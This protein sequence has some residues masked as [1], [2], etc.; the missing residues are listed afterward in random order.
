MRITADSIVDA[1][2]MTFGAKIFLPDGDIIHGKISYTREGPKLSNKD[3]IPIDA[4]NQA[5][6]FSI[7]GIAGESLLVGKQE[8]ISFDSTVYFR[9]LTRE[10]PATQDNYPPSSEGWIRYLS[11][12]GKPARIDLQKIIDSDRYLLSCVDLETGEM[13][14][15]HSIRSFETNILSMVTDWEHYNREI[16]DY[17]EEEVSLDSLL[18]APA[19]SWADL[20]L[21]VQGINIPNLQRYG[22][23]GE[24]LSQIVP[25][26]FP[27]DIRKELMTFLAWTIRATIPREDPLDFLTTIHRRFKTGPL[28]QGLVFGHVQC[29]IQQ[30]PIPQYVRIFTMA[31]RGELSKGEK[32]LT[33]NAEQEAWSKAWFRVE[34]LFPKRIDRIID[35]ANHL[36]LSQEIHADLPVSKQEA[37]N[38][39][40]AW[41]DRFALIRSNFQMRGYIQ[42]RKIGLQKTVYI[43]GAH[44]WPHTHLQYAARLGHPNQKPPY[45]QVMVMPKTAADRISRI[46]QNVV[47]IDWTA[48][49]V[50]YNLYDP[51]NDTWKYNASRFIKSFRGVRTRRLMNKEFEI[52][53][54]SDIFHLDELDPKLLD[55]MSWGFYPQSFEIGVYQDSLNPLNNQEI[56]EKMKLYLKEKLVRLHYYPQTFGR[57][58]ICLE[59]RGSIKK[60][61]SISRAAL[62]HLPSAVVMISTSEEVCIILARIPEKDIYSIL[63]ELPSIAN[64]NDVS[65]KAY[66]VYAYAGFV[67]NLYQ[68]LRRPDGTWDDDVSGLLS[69]ITN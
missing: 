33:E 21:L 27:E 59:I 69:Q 49:R 47:S 53:S 64:E 9:K 68:R 67:H 35:I 60:L 57:V 1:E 11:H 42:D 20:D 3:N 25:S 40:D 32:T 13:L 34:E 14:R 51:E 58:S 15:I 26:S 28:L 48:S 23:V 10:N 17:D 44:R 2:Q 36:N 56:H 7:T 41:L 43:G 54:S 4:K 12:R 8:R 50:N 61:Y 22:T 16:V 37:A 63:T 39:K 29:L 6:E 38:S 30:T 45:I 19:P 31:E 52:P 24:T 65:M 46:R 55:L 62:K 18:D 5:V 66:R